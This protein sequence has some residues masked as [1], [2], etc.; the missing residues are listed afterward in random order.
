M[1]REGQDGLSNAEQLT[2]NMRTAIILLEIFVV[3]IIVAFAVTF[4]TGTA[5]MQTLSV[6][7]ISPIL[8]LSLIFIYYCK[9]KKVWSFAGASILGIIGVVLRVAVSTQPNVEVGG[10]LPAGVTALYIVI[11]ALVALKSYESVL[12]LKK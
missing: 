10:G 7:F 9:R 12:E 4:T 2:V 8:V 6:G 1:S 3:A 11:G 5:E